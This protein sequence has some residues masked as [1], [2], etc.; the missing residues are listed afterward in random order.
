V[1]NVDMP[2]AL[3][4]AMFFA[5]GLI[6]LISAHGFQDLPGMPVGPGLFPKIV[7][8]SMAFFGAA[9]AV[10]AW[11]APKSIDNTLIPVAAEELP[12]LEAVAPDNT[13]DR[14]LPPFTPSLLA[15]IVVTILVMPT[16]GFVITGVLL[17]AFLV[18]LGGGSIRTG[19]IFAIAATGLV[20]VSFVH[21]L[22]VPLPVGLLG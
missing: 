9:L 8:A 15:A 21:G 18:W 10:Q 5:L 1:R 2:D 7:G 3:L 4:G 16:L 17:T 12:E 13:D 22:R 20:Y 19:V 6:V 14:W 11:L